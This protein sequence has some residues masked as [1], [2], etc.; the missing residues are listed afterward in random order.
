MVQS[1]NF[2]GIVNTFRVLL[3]PSLAVPHIVVNDLRS[4][5]FRQLKQDGIRAMAYDKDNCLTAPYVTSIHPPFKEAWAECKATFGV[6]NIVIVSNSAGTPD[7]PNGK[8]ADNLEKALG[9]SVL[10]HAEKK[11]ACGAAL[12][13]HLA[14]LQ[15]HQVA[16]VGDRILTDIVFGNL[17]GNKTIWTREIVTE[18]GD[19]KMAAKL[20]RLEHKIVDWLARRNVKP[21]PLRK[22]D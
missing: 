15:A 14:P 5:P 4:I 10:R 12:A 8:E 20:R 19:N 3:N 16:V 9:V 6:Q 2:A 1:F 21:P 18:Q 17:N 22:E 11:P 13:A 7:D